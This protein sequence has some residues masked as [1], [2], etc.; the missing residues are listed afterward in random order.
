MTRGALVHTELSA[1]TGAIHRR[2]HRHPGLAAAARGAIGLDDYRQL[3][4]R[5]YGFHR[6]FENVYV[7]AAQPSS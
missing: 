6:A 3:L 1:A 7:G 2:L 5:L 4:G